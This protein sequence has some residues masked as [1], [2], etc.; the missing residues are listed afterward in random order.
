MKKILYV[1]ILVSLFM[2]C[3][4]LKEGDVIEKQY[5]GSYF[6][7]ITRIDSTH[8]AFVPG[9]WIIVIRG[10]MDTRGRHAEREVQVD[11]RVYDSVIIG[12]KVKVDLLL[13]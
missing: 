6:K 8:T 13:K 12:M 1:L 4:K 3:M 2:A 9:V 10:P 5:R 11:K 7:I